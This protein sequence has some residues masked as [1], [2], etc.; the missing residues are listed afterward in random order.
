MQLSIWT[1][2][3]VGLVSLTT[4]FIAALVSP[5]SG[6]GWYGFVPVLLASGLMTVIIFQAT[7]QL[8]RLQEDH[9]DRQKSLDE[10][11]RLLI[12]FMKATV[13]GWNAICVRRRLDPLRLRDR[14]IYWA[15]GFKTGE[16]VE[17]TRDMIETLVARQTPQQPRPLTRGSSRQIGPKGN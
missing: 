1:M 8:R 10:V 6:G 3:W 15:S 5:I 17:L 16:M 12:W 9:A 4:I 11:S 2:R 7:R 13:R 14:T